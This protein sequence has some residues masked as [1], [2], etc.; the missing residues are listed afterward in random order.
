[1]SFEIILLDERALNVSKTSTVQELADAANSVEMEETSD[2][3][4]KLGSDMQS[5]LDRLIE[6]YGTL[7]DPTPAC[8]WAMWPPSQDIQGHRVDLSV[9]WGMAYQVLAEVEKICTNTSIVALNPQPP[10]KE[11]RNIEHEKDRFLGKHP[12][13]GLSIYV[14]QGPF[15]PCFMYGGYDE[16]SDPD[17]IAIRKEMNL[18]IDTVTTDDAVKLTELPRVLGKDANGQDVV[19]GYGPKGPYVRCMK[20]VYRSSEIDPFSISY[21]DVVKMVESGNVQ[22][23]WR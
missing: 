12:D 19:A 7:R 6:L 9:G 13:S 20:K 15:G 10:E 21:T 14:K 2:R 3:V 22:P 4:E 23:H 16:V 5:V 8:P 11:K 18:N 1:M 17:L